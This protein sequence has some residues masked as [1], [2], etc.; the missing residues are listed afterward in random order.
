MSTCVGGAAPLAAMADLVW[1]LPTTWKISPSDRLNSS[2][3]R[4]ITCLNLTLVSRYVLP[5][6]HNK[7]HHYHCS[8]MERGPTFFKMGTKRGPSAAEKGT[9][10][11]PKKRIF[12]KLL[13][14][15]E[16]ESSLKLE[17]NKF[18]GRIWHLV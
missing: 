18:S 8:H 9:K 1:I 11:G 14:V 17:K 6:V 12:D 2:L 5:I 3:F 10:W 15:Q 7:F 4:K 16:A 13:Y